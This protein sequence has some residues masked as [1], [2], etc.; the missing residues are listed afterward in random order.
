ML[1]RGEKL[2]VDFTNR[3]I[4]Y[5][6]PVDPV[7]AKWSA[8]PVHHR[9]AHGNSPEMMLAQT[10]LIRHDRQIGAR[11]VAIEAIRNTRPPTM[12]WAAPPT[13]SP[14]RSKS[15]VL[16]F[17]DLGMEAI[18]EFEVKDMPVTVAVDSSGASVRQHR[19]GGVGKENQGIQDSGGGG[20]TFFASPP[21]VG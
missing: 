16:A 20:V 21:G 2:P 1:A 5:V 6:G 4:Y 17:G 3:V 9:H 8:Q 7:R 14:R 12:A 11:P 13:S 18:Y 15:R 19:A 10:G